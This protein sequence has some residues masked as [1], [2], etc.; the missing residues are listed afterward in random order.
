[1]GGVD[2]VT[3]HESSLDDACI[4]HGLSMKNPFMILGLSGRYLSKGPFYKF[5]SV[6]GNILSHC[7]NFLINSFCVPDLIGHDRNDTSKRPQKFLYPCLAW[8]YLNWDCLATWLRSLGLDAWLRSFVCAPTV[9][10][11]GA[12]VLWL[13]SL[14][15]LAELTWMRSPGWAHLA[16]IRSLGSLGWERLARTLHLGRAAWQEQLASLLRDRVRW[17]WKDPSHSLLGIVS[18]EKSP[19]NSLLGN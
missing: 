13:R 12:E 5:L 16:G 1:M 4:L 14:S 10:I 2:G 8:L 19:L 7:I 9:E 17:W 11:N 18:L 15:A 3:M 6:L